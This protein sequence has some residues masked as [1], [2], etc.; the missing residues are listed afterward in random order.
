MWDKLT[1]GY[2]KTCD[3]NSIFLQLGNVT[4][5]S[6][7]DTLAREVEMVSPKG[8]IPVRIGSS[9]EFDVTVKGARGHWWERKEEESGL[10]WVVSE[11]VRGEKRVM[12][13]SERSGV[14]LL[15]QLVR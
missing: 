6:W 13:E 5:R 10:V 7:T 2:G 11:E 3:L 1:R 4:T 12:E 14:V 9:D 15:V 8:T